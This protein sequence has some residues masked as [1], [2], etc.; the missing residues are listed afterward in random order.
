MEGRGSWEGIKLG[1]R[2]SGTNGT[3]LGKKLGETVAR[4]YGG[5]GKRV[6]GEGETVSI[7]DGGE[8]CA[9]EIIDGCEVG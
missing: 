7:I 2:V 8:V 6:Q 1:Q 9:L 5:M 3:T 4:L